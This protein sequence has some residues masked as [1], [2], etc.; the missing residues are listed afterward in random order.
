M[1][2]RQPI[3]RTHEQI[4]RLVQAFEACTLPPDQ[5]AHHAH[6]TVAL[7]YLTQLPLDQATDKMRTAIQRFAA[8]HH[9]TQLYNE[10]ITLF[11]MKLLDHFLSIA[12]P[13]TALA[14]VTQQALIA[15]GSMRFVFSH[16]SKA[17]VFSEK[18]RHQWVDPD[19][20]PLSFGEVAKSQPT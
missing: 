12:Q 13:N 4:E 17:L 2:T 8:F 18:A 19:L 11:W 14:D 1:D 20:I 6:M 10:T 15:L 9:Q 5:F 16:Y 3:Y 7:W